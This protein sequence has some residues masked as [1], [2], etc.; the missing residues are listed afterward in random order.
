MAKAGTLTG[1]INTTMVSGLM[2]KSMVLVF[3]TL[4]EVSTMVHG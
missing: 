3:I 2:T 1:Q 4:R